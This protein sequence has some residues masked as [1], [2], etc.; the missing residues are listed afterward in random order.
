M[1]ARKNE[2]WTRVMVRLRT[3]VELITFLQNTCPDSQDDPKG[4]RSNLAA[5]MALKTCK[6]II[7]SNPPKKQISPVMDGHWAGM[8]DAVTRIISAVELQVF[9]PR[10][11][12]ERYSKEGS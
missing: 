12:P 6:N 2:I 8:M 10:Q 3:C 4:A 5:R 11:Y 9:D 1:D 7:N